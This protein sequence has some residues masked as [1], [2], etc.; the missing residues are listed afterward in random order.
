MKESEILYAAA[1]SM[2]KGGYSHDWLGIGCG[3]FA[4]HIHRIAYYDDNEDAA[5]QRIRALVGSLDPDDLR[6]AGW[7]KDD[8]I[9]ALTIAA[10]CAFEEEKAQ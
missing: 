6:T 7:N 3:C 1:E 8:A 5:D 10:D 9:A 4:D 2:R